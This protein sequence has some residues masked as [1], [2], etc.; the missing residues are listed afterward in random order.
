MACK[1]PG[2]DHKTLPFHPLPFPDKQMETQTCLVGCPGLH[3]G[4]LVN[5]DL[6]PQLQMPE[7]VHSTHLEFPMLSLH[8][9][10]HIKLPTHTSYTHIKPY[11]CACIQHTCTHAHTHTYVMQN[12][13]PASC[14]PSEHFHHKCVPERRAFSKPPLLPTVFATHQ[15]T[16]SPHNPISLNHTTNLQHFHNLCPSN[17]PASV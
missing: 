17:I 10:L 16:V 11:L 3:W 2:L 15:T 1:I 9:S 5:Q 6:H 12:H 13:V 14:M 8:S 4:L 7:S